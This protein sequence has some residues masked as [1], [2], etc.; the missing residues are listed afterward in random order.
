MSEGIARYQLHSRW[1]LPADVDHAWDVV[2]S[3]LASDD[4][5]AWWSAVTVEGRDADGIH[6]VTSSRL[7][8]VLRFVLDDVQVQ[9]PDRV[10]VRAS[11]DL[12]GQ[13]IVRIRPDGPCSAIE[14]DWEVETTRRWMRVVGP[15]ARPAFVAAHAQVMRQGRKA[16]VRWLSPQLPVDGWE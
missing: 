8:Y 9:R 12:Q 7:G 3:L 16:F 10:T 13:G 4:P 11:G 2:E 1:R 5:F 15:V 6:V 14:V